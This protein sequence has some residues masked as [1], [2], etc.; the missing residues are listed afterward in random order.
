MSLIDIADRR[1]L[2]LDDYLVDAFKDGATLKLHHPTPREAALVTDKPWEGCMSCFNTVI[3]ND[4]EYRL[5][6]RGW[7]IDLTDFN[8]M[9][10]SRPPTMCLATSRD[11]IHW[12]RPAINQFDYDGAPQNNIIWM[13]EGE[14]LF[15]MHGFSPFIDG[16]PACPSEKRWKAVGAP[17]LHPGQGLRLMSSPDGITWRLEPGEPLFAGY[18]LDSHNIVFWDALRSEYRACFRHW[19]KGTMGKGLRNIMTATSKDLVEWSDLAELDY[20]GMPPE[21][22]YTNNVQPYYRAP[23]VFVGFPG[24][25]VERKWTPTMDQLPELEHRRKRS[26]RSE[27]YGTAISDAVFMSS[28]DGVEYRRWGE[29]F[30]RPGLRAEEQWTYADNYLT[31][32]MLETDSDLPG[33]GRELSFYNTEN[34]WR[35]QSTTIRRYTLR[36]DGFVSLNAPLSGGELIT[37]SLSVKGNRMSLNVSTSAAGSVRVEIQDESGAPMPGF[38]LDDCWEI[39]GDA[40]DYTVKWKDDPD[41]GALTGKPI[42]LRFALSDADLYSFKFA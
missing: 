8:G 4:G 29:A 37:K 34:Y 17:W 41:L 19:T 16:N 1:E 23:H 26:E 9:N 21:Q 25:Y 35:G 38:S 7:Q 3:D 20:P 14:E 10:A 2:M 12:E 33:G 13:G 24:R 42:R 15:G 11:G 39:V 27:R 36:L 22:F 32:G 18:A 6:Y 5:Y 40:L 31:W 28:R 30:I